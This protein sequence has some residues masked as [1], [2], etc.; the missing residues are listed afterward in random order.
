MGCLFRI[1]NCPEQLVLII[2]FD[3]VERTRAV[4]HISSVFRVVFEKS[5][6]LVSEMLEANLQHIDLHIFIT[7]E[8]SMHAYSVVCL[9]VEVSRAAD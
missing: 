8:Y 5:R 3:R 6:T 9:V 1:A 2:P 7:A 4:R